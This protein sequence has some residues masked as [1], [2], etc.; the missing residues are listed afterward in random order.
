MPQNKFSTLHYKMS[1]LYTKC[2][3]SNL[4]LPDKCSI[5]KPIFKIALSHKIPL[6]QKKKNLSLS[7]CLTQKMHSL[8]NTHNH[9][10]E[11]CEIL[12]K[13]ISKKKFKK[14]L[15]KGYQDFHAPKSGG[16]QVYLRNG[17][18]VLIRLYRD[19]DRQTGRRAQIGTQIRRCED[20]EIWRYGDI[21]IPIVWNWLAGFVG[22]FVSVWFDSLIQIFVLHKK[23]F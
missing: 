17:R 14:K 12:Q 7:K 18:Y 6:L 3:I 16:G 23:I 15:K 1:Y 13:K 4:F 5:K 11:P 19:G 21:E 10:K 20:V 22:W 8:K 9:K 2:Y